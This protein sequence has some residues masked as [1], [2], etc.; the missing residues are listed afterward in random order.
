M[1]LGPGL[2]ALLT[3]VDIAVPALH[4]EIDQLNA[5]GFAMALIFLVLFL[6]MPFVYLEPIREVSI[7]KKRKEVTS[8]NV[9][10]GDQDEN[11]VASTKDLPVLPKLFNPGLV[12][13]SVAKFISQFYQMVFETILTPLTHTVLHFNPFQNSIMYACVAVMA[14]LSLV[15]VGV[16]SGRRVSDRTLMYV[17]QLFEGIGVV[18]FGC[19]WGARDGGRP[20]SPY[21]ALILPTAF[22]VLGLPF[23]WSPV[24]SL[25]MKLTDIRQQGAAQSV[26]TAVNASASIAGPLVAGL[27]LGAD[28]TYLRPLIFLLGSMWLLNCVIFVF[29]HKS[30]KP[31]TAYIAKEPKASEKE[32]LL[33]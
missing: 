8:I 2:Q 14:V 20:D 31:K 24:S 29:T 25:A 18:L 33:P 23:A 6:L 26:L 7:A 16:A 22:I 4:L 11:L 27:F 5:P 32:P 10:V 9:A 13:L 21:V 12:A 19:F 3:H 28:K 1:L 15:S 30:L 17:G